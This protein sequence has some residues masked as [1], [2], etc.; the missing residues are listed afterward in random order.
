MADNGDQLLEQWRKRAEANL[1][2]MNA[3]VEAGT[4]MREAQLSYWRS[5]YETVT[6]A[7]AKITRCVQEGA[8]A[9]GALPNP[10]ELPPSG[11]PFVDNAYR[12]MMKASQQFLQSATGAFGNAAPAARSEGRKAA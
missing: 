5:L 12:E 7:N 11:F 10:G 2:V 4:K 9:V 1:R 3:M 6:E 8:G